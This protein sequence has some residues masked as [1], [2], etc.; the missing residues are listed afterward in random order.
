MRVS[1]KSGNPFLR[2]FAE[3]KIAAESTPT[4]SRE[5]PNFYLIFLLF[6][7]KSIQ[8]Q[9]KIGWYFFYNL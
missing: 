7:I 4:F 1:D 9:L 2:F 8:F 3:K 5:R 6:S